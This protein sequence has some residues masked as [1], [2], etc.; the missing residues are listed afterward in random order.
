MVKFIAIATAALLFSLSHRFA[1]ATP[2]PGQGTW[3]TTLQARDLNK[4]GTAD[5][6]Y[7][8]SQDVTWLSSAAFAQTNSFGVQG[9]AAGGWTNWQT[10]NTWVAAMN[11]QNYGGFSDWRLPTVSRL[12]DGSLSSEVT[13]MFYQTLGNRAIRDVELNPAGGATQ[14]NTGPFIIPAGYLGGSYIW[15]NAVGAA[16]SESTAGSS[17][18]FGT[19]QGVL[20]PVNPDSTAYAWV[21]RTGDVGAVPEP[22]TYLLTL[23]G[24]GLACVVARRS[25]RR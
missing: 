15:S 7:D 4:D 11:A 3:E 12:A 5:A 16:A 14:L 2:V 10:A 6:F 18:N 23:M 24:L 1:A 21:V 17:W 13:D 9:I 22:G 25:T 19:Y 20:G 8:T